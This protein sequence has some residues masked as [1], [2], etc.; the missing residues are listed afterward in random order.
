MAIL[1]AVKGQSD[2][3]NS[4][5]ISGIKERD[6]KWYWDTDEPVQ[7]TKW[8]HYYSKD[9]G[10]NVAKYYAGY[11]CGYYLKNTS[12]PAFYYSIPEIGGYTGNAEDRVYNHYM[13][14]QVKK[15]SKTWFTYNFSYS[16][17]SWTE[18]AM[19]QFN[20]PAMEDNMGFICEW[21]DNFPKITAVYN[22]DTRTILLVGVGDMQDY[23]AETSRNAP[24]SRWLSE[25]EYL[26]CSSSVTSIGDYA[27]YRAEALSN[28][29]GTSRLKKIGSHAFAECDRLNNVGIINSV[30]EIGTA[31]F[32][33]DN[34]LVVFTVPK[35]LAKADSIFGTERT[36]EISVFFENGTAIP[37]NMFNGC[38]GLTS[39]D[40]TGVTTIGYA[41]FKNCTDLYTINFQKVTAIGSGAFEGCRSLITMTI[42]SYVRTI[43]SMAFSGC[44]LYKV[45]M[46]GSAPALES[47]NEFINNSYDLTFIVPSSYLSGYQSGYWVN[48]HIESDK[49]YNPESY[50][51][52]DDGWF[53][54][55]SEANNII[56]TVSSNLFFRL[57]ERNNRKNIKL[58]NGT[59]DFPTLRKISQKGVCFGMA[60]TSLLNYEEKPAIT[61][62]STTLKKASQVDASRLT[63]NSSSLNIPLKD[64]M[65]LAHIWQ[66]SDDAC[67]QRKANK[68]KYK[69]LI[70][71]I[72]NGTPTVI[73]LYGY[74]DNKK[75]NHAVVGYL[76]REF[77]GK[78][79][80]YV[81][82]PND[83]GDNN[84]IVIDSPKG[85]IKNKKYS[86]KYYKGFNN[87][88]TPHEDAS[89]LSYYNNLDG[90]YD[91]VKNGGKLGKEDGFLLEIVNA[92]NPV[93]IDDNTAYFNQIILAADNNE[94]G[95][96]SAEFYYVDD[97]VDVSVVGDG[98]GNMETS[99]V[100]C[101]T[102]LTVTASPNSEVV[103]GGN[104]GQIQ[105][106]IND[107]GAEEAA[108]ITFI[109]LEDY[110]TVI[111]GDASGDISVIKDE[112]TGKI[113][114]GGYESFEITAETD[115]DYITKE[116]TNGNADTVYEVSVTDNDVDIQIVENVLT[117]GNVTLD[118]TAY[119]YTGN[120]IVPEITVTYDG[121]TLEENTDY[122][123]SISNNVNIGTAAVVVTG[124]GLYKG[125]VRKTFEIQAEAP[126]IVSGPEDVVAAV[127]TTVSFGIEV[128][129][130]NLTYQWQ[131]QGLTSAEWRNFA[132]ATEAT[133]TKTLAKNWDGWKVRCVVTDSRGNT[134]V[135]DTATITIQVE[136]GIEITSQP[137]SVTTRAGESV[138]FSV[139]VI[140]SGLTYQW[141]YQG[142]T[143]TKWTNFANATSA[144]MTKTPSAS[145][146]GW[147]VRCVITDGSGNTVTSDTAVITIE[148]PLTIIAQPTSVTTQAGESVTF[149]V[150]ATGNSLSYQWQYQGKTSTKWTNFVNATSASMTK[151]PSASWDG[152]KVRC[153]VT[154][155]SGNTV[156]SD[157]AVITIE[158][159]P[160]AITGQ[161][162]SVTTQAGKSVT[163]SVTATG[164]SLSYQWQY[165]GRTSTK[166][167]NFANATSASMTKMPSA[168]WDGWKV[169]CIVTDGSGNTV[170][171][172]IAVIT[173][174]TQP[175]AITGQPASVTTQAGKSVTF[176]V[177]ATGNSL[178]Y[179]WQYQGRTS[180]KWTNFANATS[181]SM[182]KMPSASWDGWK[183]RCVVTDGSGNTVASDTAVITIEEETLA[184]TAQPESVTTQAGGSVTF[185]VTA[186]GSSLSYQW[187][188]EDKTSGN[189]T[190][191]T[192]V[193]GASMTV[194]LEDLGGWKV[195]CKV[196][197]GSGNTVTSDTAVI[198]I[199]GWLSDYSYTVQEDRIKLTSYTGTGTAVTV[200][201]FAV[202]DGTEYDIV[203]ISKYLWK[204]AQ[205][206]VFERGIMFPDDSS[207]LFSSMDSLKT[208]DLS[209]VD[210]SNVTAMNSMF[211]DCSSLTSLDL[212]SFDTSNVTDM[213]DMFWKCSSLTSLDVSG[214]DTSKVTTMSDMFR[215]CSSLTSLDV[216]NFDTSNVTDISGMFRDCSRLTGLDLSGFDT[217][218]VR[219][220]DSMFWKCSSLTSLDL[221]GFD[222]SNVTDMYGVFW[223]CS[224]LTSLDVSGF[225]TSNVT[226]IY[227]MFRNC[228]SLT[229][230]DLS[231]FN[232][233]M[234]ESDK[235][236]IMLNGCTALSQIQA[237]LHLSQNIS[238]PGTFIG[239]DGKEYT[240]LPKSLQQSI[241]LTLADE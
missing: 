65:A 146:D 149:S 68:Y 60:A 49:D 157:I 83:G 144:S 186:T 36:A 151:T 12:V 63:L 48:Y 134:T 196:T 31:A 191:I 178:S 101:N 218:N 18:G 122:T 183:V 216:S 24:W 130:E 8:Q 137:A 81:Y 70:Q 142:R 42:P 219:D 204:N 25:A 82:D 125:K 221:S 39:L 17:P 190:D 114:I 105:A 52:S 232:L 30:T 141:Q 235:C 210:T 173:I 54:R 106:A 193:A 50:L 200:P 113:Q 167:T 180:T 197:D 212:S 115:E 89:D 135:S 66:A 27:F 28:F 223:N 10:N 88:V 172:D 188:Y 189:W 46:E 118:N 94:T 201:G 230:L 77:E 176:S 87:V 37:D 145:W 100:S 110:E 177:T 7:Y 239:T 225:D 152:W 69:N 224:S 19:F 209:E 74:G 161:P 203:E 96:D 155:G 45:K 147:K 184:I 179:Q 61:D 84:K 181:A 59:D 64:W 170:A 91:T 140:G 233:L 75:S 56:G 22:S 99:F 98:T 143:S 85:S 4:Y 228:S 226:N 33:K 156:A 21:G 97:G 207:Y 136:E 164:N 86:W 133:L 131:Y 20:N 5:I 57:Y 58:F 11:T 119:T 71:R 104:G 236:S 44:G 205:S 95:E 117:Q 90:L 241:I 108:Q 80:I 194:M 163:F 227:G 166:W 102:E 126:V 53:V 169:R 128:T 139:T 195:R 1:N 41:S 23:T 55:N 103:F 234:V 109:D 182:T 26:K 168:S 185:S 217:S 76:V 174:E 43:N 51:P 240:S 220:M 231:S 35:S 214:F 132:N 29:E 120:P 211:R 222:T 107:S 171:S 215:N 202:I 187:Q 116:V 160:L 47:G 112:N 154:D 78:T 2:S 92:F 129:G 72:E 148:E 9:S 79:E 198:S 123:V 238:L 6:S 127:G 67:S 34:E 93:S 158:T 237:P 153:I 162:A 206:L 14:F 192:G 38:K 208:I 73:H 165:Q 159:Q 150:T 3:F 15:Y 16:Y 229:S 124:T 62:W 175:L 32:D 111:T 199:D 121:K 40:L 213:H 13:G 138:T